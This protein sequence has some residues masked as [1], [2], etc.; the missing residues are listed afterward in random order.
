MYSPAPQTEADLHRPFF[1]GIRYYVLEKKGTF[2]QQSCFQERE[3]FSC[4][5]TFQVTI[6]CVRFFDIKGAEKMH[7]L[8]WPLGLQLFAVVTKSLNK[9]ATSNASVKL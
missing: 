5:K 9:R 7:L 6:V 1:G 8:H 2:L 3:E 4:G